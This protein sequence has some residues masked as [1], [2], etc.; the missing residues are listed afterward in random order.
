MK[1]LRTIETVHGKRIGIDWAGCVDIETEGL[2]RRL[3]NGEREVFEANS[4]LKVTT[5]RRLIRTYKTRK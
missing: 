4:K 3:G 5:G 2:K 1:E